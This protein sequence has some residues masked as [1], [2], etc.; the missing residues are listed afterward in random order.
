[1]LSVANARCDGSIEFTSQKNKQVSISAPGMAILSSVPQELGTVRGHLNS[2]AQVTAG[3]TGNRVG[4]SAN[5]F[6]VSQAGAAGTTS[7]KQQCASW[8]VQR[9]CRED[10][11]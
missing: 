2:T 9:L 7:H 6:L 11:S 1:M 5:G 10:R 4:Y 8:I 3:A